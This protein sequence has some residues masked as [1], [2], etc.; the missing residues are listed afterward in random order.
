MGMI[1]A[2]INGNTPS[3]FTN[4][5]T[6]VGLQRQWR[7]WDSVTGK[8]LDPGVYSEQLNTATHDFTAQAKLQPSNSLVAYNN[9]TLKNT[10]PADLAQKAASF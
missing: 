10:A 7:P 9:T 2:M 5:R 6:Y 1:K 8:W 4:N 3:R